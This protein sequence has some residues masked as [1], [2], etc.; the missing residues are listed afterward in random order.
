[1]GFHVT[2]WSGKARSG[3]IALGAVVLVQ[4]AIASGYLTALDTAIIHRLP[5]A[6]VGPPQAASRLTAASGGRLDARPAADDSSAIARVQDRDVYGALLTDASPRRL[7]IASAASLPAAQALTKSFTSQDR[8]LIVEDIKPMPAS[9]PHGNAPALIVVAWALGGYLGAMLTG[10]L[11]GMRSRSVRHLS[12]RLAVLAGYALTSAAAMAAVA[13]AGLGALTGHPLA[14]IGV[15]T[16]FVFAVAS[17]TSMMQSLLRLAGVLLS[18]LVVVLLG[19]PA[20]G[21]GQVPP[22]MMSVLWR[23]IAFVTPNPAAMNAV[24]DFQSFSGHT[25]NQALLTVGLWATVPVLVM[26]LLT[27][28]KASPAVDPDAQAT[29][30]AET[31]GTALAIGGTA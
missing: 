29:D 26:A 27:L 21:G 28:R 31:G 7:V 30:L 15:G 10:R 11:I 23:A 5:V 17:F 2:R 13:D 12:G 8:T 6:V 4:L 22:Q 18:V 14:L 25:A 3:A 24:R 20:A 19:N 9:D 16:L 1:M